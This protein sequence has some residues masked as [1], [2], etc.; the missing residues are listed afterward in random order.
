MK[1]QEADLQ[2]EGYEKSLQILCLEHC[3]MPYALDT[4]LCPNEL[5]I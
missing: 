2:G 3:T 5:T 1:P 4:C